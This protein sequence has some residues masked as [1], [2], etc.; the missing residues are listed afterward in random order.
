MEKMIAVRQEKELTRDSIKV[1]ES[2]HPKLKT[3]NDETM[4]KPRGYTITKEEIQ[5]ITGI[6]EDREM[7]KLLAN[8]KRCILW[9]RGIDVIYS[10]KI[11]GYE[12]VSVQKHVSVLFDNRMASAERKLRKEGQKLLMIRDDDFESDHQRSLRIHLAQQA[13]DSAG[14]IN[15]QRSMSLMWNSK[16]ETL[17]KLS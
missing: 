9:L 6:S 1:I 11:A 14:K 4:E 15:S 3:L 5:R 8:W 12:F 17:P 10:H 2:R 16:P 7:S 13:H